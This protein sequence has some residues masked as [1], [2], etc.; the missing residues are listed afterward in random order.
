MLFLP[1]AERF[2]P[3][4]RIVMKKTLTPLFAVL[5]LALPALVWAGPGSG[6]SG[7]CLADIVASLPNEPPDAQE[8]ADL[9]HLREEEKLARDVYRAMDDLWGLRI[10]GNIANSEQTHMDA[11]LSLLEKYGIPDPSQGKYKAPGVFRDPELQ[12]LYGQLVDQGSASLIDALI[13][14]ATIEDMDIYDIL[15]FIERADNEDILTVYQNLMKGSRN[16]LRSFYGQ[17]QANG[18]DYAPQFIDLALFDEI[19]SSPKETG[20]YDADGI[21]DPD[22]C[23]GSGGSGGSGGG[24]G[25]KPGWRR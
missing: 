20:F 11:V 9:V 8:T 24:R 4:R 12:D 17:L 15:V 25:G 19:V 22:A 14:G 5:L 1:R 10:F 2:R 21:P 13:V 23:G 16:H 18:V 3:H 7:G 6:G